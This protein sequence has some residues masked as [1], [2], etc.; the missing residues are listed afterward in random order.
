EASEAPR[1]DTTGMRATLEKVIMRDRE[2]FEWYPDN[3]FDSLDILLNVAMYRLDFPVAVSIQQEYLERRIRL[4]GPRDWRVTDTR[5]ILEEIK[6]MA[7]VD[8]IRR[9]QWE[10]AN[11]NFK[12]GLHR[13]NQNHYREALPLYEQALATH[14]QLLG[15]TY[16]RSVVELSDLGDIY[17][18]LG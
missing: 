8:L 18:R 12:E 14:R 7:G 3:L 6:Q 11:S 17:Q 4:H 15:K 10:E 1:R 13:L 2:L 9:Q 16:W 5:L